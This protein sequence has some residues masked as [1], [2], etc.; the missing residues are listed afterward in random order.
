[1]R[2]RR[3]KVP[4]L[5]GALDVVS[6]ALFRVQIGN[7]VRI[8]RGLMITHGHV[9]IDGRTIIGRDCQ[10]NPWVTIGLSNSKKLGF[11]ARGSDD[12]R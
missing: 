9:V 5:P 11:S 2:L 10:I 6:R 3:A 12:R 7:D 4:L 1:M 8:G